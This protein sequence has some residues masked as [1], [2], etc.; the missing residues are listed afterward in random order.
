M[1]KSPVL[2]VVVGICLSALVGTVHSTV[3]GA[4]TSS[5]RVVNLRTEHMTDPIGIDEA[6]P[7]LSWQVQGAATLKSWEL[8]AANT[9]AELEQ[10]KELW[11]SGQVASS[12]AGQTYLSTVKLSS[13][14]R[15]VWQVRVWDSANRVSPWSAPAVFEMG[16]LAP[17][18]WSAHWIENSEYH[19]SQADGSESPLPVFEK[20]FRITAPISRARL[21]ITGLGMYAAKLNGRPITQN[22]LE[23]GQTTY[24]AEVDYRTYDLTA[25]I[26]QGTQRFRIETGSGAYQRVPTNGRYFFSGF[27]EEAHA[28]G[29]PKV[30][31]QLEISY[32]DGRREVISTDASWRTALG[33]TTFSAWW[34]GEE[35]DARRGRTDAAELSPNLHWID[36]SLVKLSATSSP[37]ETTPL[38]A[39]P[40]PPV[41]VAETVQPVSIKPL[42]SGSWLLDFGI[43][44]SGL[45]HLNVSGAAGTK[46]TIIPSEKLQ[47]DG[48]LDVASTGAGPGKTIAYRYSL[49]GGAPE[50]WRPQFTYNG[51]RYL[52]VDG[53]AHAPAKETVT[54]D[55]IHATNPS[56]SEFAS[57]NPLLQTIRTMTRRAIESNMMSV[58]TDCPDRE[59]GPYTGD[60]LQNLD[61][62]L[63]DYDLSSYEPQMVR[64]MATAQRKPGDAHPGLIANI[65]PEYHRVNPRMIQRQGSQI[66]FLDEV[67]WGGAIIRIPWRLYEVYGDT[68][69]MARYY[70]NMVKWLDYEAANRAANKGA[71]PGLG[72]WAA[73][74][75]TTPQLLP[76]LAGYYT[77]ATDM[78]KIAG[79]LG[80]TDDQ[81][82]YTA[83]AEDLAKD[84]NTRFRKQDDK[85][86]FYGSDSET[87]NAMALDAGLVAAADQPQIVERLIAS[88]RRAGN[89]ITPGS[90][91]LG[92]LFRALQA[93]GRSDILYDMVVNPT[94]PGYGYLATA[95]YT[96]LPEGFKGEG[97]QDHHFLG[98]VDAWL[99]SGLAGIRQASN[100]IGYK[101]VEIAPAVLPQLNQVSGTWQSPA[102]AVRS[103]WS[104]AGDHG[105]H[106][107]VDIPAGVTGEVHVPLS[108]NQRVAATGEGAPQLERQMAQEAIYKVSP[109]RSSFSVQD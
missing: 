90:V 69:T 10:G 85:G 9:R 51:F 3:A 78:A 42:G 41:R 77:A 45:V 58:L 28:F 5:L 8:R 68:R 64:N 53:L 87:S 108:G 37:S 26:R 1:K 14:Q 47:A 43:N 21:Y 100:S 55:L 70:D 80:K 75:T 94:A 2:L 31:A 79:L 88:V 71:I 103:T 6:A 81:A 61:A 56:S 106:L 15:V 24:A 97:S 95:G 27:F 60:N 93:A 50:S 18:D 82:K 20:E 101:T 4:Q 36:A 76:I 16:L 48:T 107:D 66:E 109:G 65:A 35:Y 52:Q 17:A 59:K 91:G 72:D 73:A 63:T 57:S 12:G 62:L 96:T 98:E 46:I 33:P 22:V 102:G 86:V 83:L 25:Q 34:A 32:A 105:L 29:E 92:P 67:N 54:V 89:H 104:K 74:D 23:P 13:R 44:R 49:A 84:F 99:I 11:D 30:I 19:Y 40:R 7:L 39:D 38:R